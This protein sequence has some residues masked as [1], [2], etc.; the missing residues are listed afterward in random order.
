MGRFDGPALRSLR[1]VEQ[2]IRLMLGRAIV[3]TQARSHLLADESVPGSM[4][5]KPQ[6]YRGCGVFDP[7]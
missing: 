1:Q 4:G 7:R 5:V 2:P 6:R 3:A